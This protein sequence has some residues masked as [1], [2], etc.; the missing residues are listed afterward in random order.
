MTK[1]KTL[2]ESSKRLSKRYKFKRTLA[3]RP[4]IV[5]ILHE[6]DERI[7]RVTPVKDVLIWEPMDLPV[8]DPANANK[9]VT[10][11]K[12]PSVRINREKTDWP[13]R[14][15]FVEQLLDVSKIWVV[16]A[17]GRAPKTSYASSSGSAVPYNVGG[18]NLDMVE[19]EKPKLMVGGVGH[20][21]QPLGSEKEMR[22]LEKGIRPQSMIYGSDTVWIEGKPNQCIDIYLCNILP[23]SLTMYN[24]AFYHRDV[25]HLYLDSLSEHIKRFVNNGHWQQ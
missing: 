17:D 16:V 22:N 9:P 13:F 14:I 3:T 18:I 11:E 5:K 21:R 10:I 4:S 19:I 7:N 8:W 2:R 24:C 6:R 1:Q 15:E 23:Q 25:A 20:F 12:P